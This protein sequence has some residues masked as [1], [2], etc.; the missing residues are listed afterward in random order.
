MCPGFPTPTPYTSK[1][2]SVSASSECRQRGSVSASSECR[3]RGSVSASSE[4]RQRGSVSASSECRSARIA[5]VR[6]KCTWLYGQ[7]CSLG[8]LGP[9]SPSRCR[10]RTCT[11]TACR[12]TA[13]RAQRIR[14]TQAARRSA[15]RDRWMWAKMSLGEGES[16]A[17]RWYT[18][19]TRITSWACDM[20]CEPLGA[21]VVWIPSYRLPQ[22]L[23]HWPSPD[24]F[25]RR[26]GVASAIRAPVL[27]GRCAASPHVP[28][29]FPFL[30]RALPRCA[31]RR[32]GSQ[33]LVEEVCNKVW[34]LNMLRFWVPHVVPGADGAGTVAAGGSRAGDGDAA[35]GPKPQCP[36]GESLHTR[37]ANCSQ[38]SEQ[39]LASMAQLGQL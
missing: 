16:T 25:L 2:G 12:D 6:W 38:P 18:T 28:L 27:S 29:A 36:Y 14:R 20:N 31:L 17:E 13:R 32:Y 19:S 35:S 34:L 11:W 24:T 9:P 26:K 4:C 21:S 22:S 15:G 10:W 33:A 3:Q 23:I 1:R 7:S 8:L 37:F 39:V 30:R 5:S